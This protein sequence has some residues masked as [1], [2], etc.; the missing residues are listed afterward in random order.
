MEKQSQ[1]QPCLFPSLHH[2]RS[3]DIQCAAEEYYDGENNKAVYSVK[4]LLLSVI[5]PRKHAL[6]DGNKGPSFAYMEVGVINFLFANE[7]TLA[8]E[9]VEPAQGHLPGS[10]QTRIGVTTFHRWQNVLQ[11][12]EALGEM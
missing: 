8:L 2:R 9:I 10:R 4:K 7:E 5:Q 3:P 11:E 6:E 12:T 1:K